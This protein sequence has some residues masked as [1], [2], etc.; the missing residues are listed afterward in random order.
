MKIARPILLSRLNRDAVE[1]AL[2]DV[3]A[4]IV[5]P[6]PI[7]T[8]SLRAAL[9]RR[10]GAVVGTGTRVAAWV[11]IENF[12]LVL[13]NDVRV[14]RRCVFQGLAQI[15]VDD[16]WVV[17]PRTLLSTATVSSSGL[18]IHIPIRFASST[19]ALRDG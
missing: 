19:Q 12:N 17:P 3:V 13:G 14:G 4:R 11:R 8:H 7:M 5:L 15:E 16:G 1:R 9:L 18:V 10:L 2:R 6:L